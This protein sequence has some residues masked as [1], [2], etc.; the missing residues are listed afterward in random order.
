M[1][2]AGARM[3]E[4]VTPAHLHAALSERTALIAVIGDQAHL[5]EIPVQAMIEAG[6]A[7]GIPVLVDAA[8][9]R[10][11]LSPAGDRGLGAVY[12]SHPFRKVGVTSSLARADVK[13]PAA[14]S[15]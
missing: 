11:P 15:Q 4:V 8:A 1:R 9:E 3:V 5:G 14:W 13:R 6:R 7:R 10:P 2:A 12:T